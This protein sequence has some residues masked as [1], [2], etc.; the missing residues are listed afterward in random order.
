MAQ[1]LIDLSIFFENDVISDPRDTNRRYTTLL[2][3]I[4][5]TTL[6]VFFLVSKQ[7]IYQMLRV[8]Q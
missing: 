5:L 4:P 8:G 6:Q 2:T 1:K 3:K 7:K